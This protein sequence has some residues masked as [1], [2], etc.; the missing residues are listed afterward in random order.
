MDLIVLPPQDILVDPPHLVTLFPSLLTV[1]KETVNSLNKLA[2]LK[3]DSTPPLSEE[4]L[5]ASRFRLPFWL[6]R[7]VWWTDMVLSSS[8][9]PEVLDP[10]RRRTLRHVFAED[11]SR[12]HPQRDCTEFVSEGLFP[13]RWVRRPLGDRV[14]Y[15][16]SSRL[17]S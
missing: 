15:E 12:F 2:I 5:E 10:K 8:A 7:R 14:P 13:T 6:S 4:P 3:A 16:P 9:I 11:T 1:K 17:A